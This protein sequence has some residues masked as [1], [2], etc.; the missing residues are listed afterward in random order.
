MGFFFLIQIPTLNPSPAHAHMHTYTQEAHTHKQT[1]RVQ[2]YGMNNTNSKKQNTLFPF[3]KS[4]WYSIKNAFYLYMLREILLLYLE[5][6]TCIESNT[7]YIGNVRNLSLERSPYLNNIFIFE[8][9]MNCFLYTL[10]KRVCY[11]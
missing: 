2:Y 11:L 3:E 8:S 7:M 9:T 10:N 4:S 1:P 6:D 5:E